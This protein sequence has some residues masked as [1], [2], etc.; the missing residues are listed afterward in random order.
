MQNKQESKSKD[1]NP[2]VDCDSEN[3]GEMKN[4]REYLAS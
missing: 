2:G 1:S 4:N 3:S